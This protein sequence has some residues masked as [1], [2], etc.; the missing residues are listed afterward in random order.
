[1]FGLRFLL[2]RL[3]DEA[4]AVLYDQG[5]AFAEL[6]ELSLRRSAGQISDVE[7]V[8]QET[9]LLDRLSAIR[10]REAEESA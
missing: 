9:Q 5:R 7:Y 4:D 3:R 6:S 8:E 10:A 1:M 2:E